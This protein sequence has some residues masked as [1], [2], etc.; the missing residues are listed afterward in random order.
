MEREKPEPNSDEEDLY[1]VGEMHDTFGRVDIPV[2]GLRPEVHDSK[3]NIVLEGTFRSEEVQEQI[4]SSEKLAAVLTF[5][6]EKRLHSSWKQRLGTI[7]VII[8]A[9]SLGVE[10][11]R[12]WKDINDLKKFISDKIHDE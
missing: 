4:K 6:E 9:I 11:H 5:I 2:S 10:H 7:S 3:G 1:A 12:D 8:G